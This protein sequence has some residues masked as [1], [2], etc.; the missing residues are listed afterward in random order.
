MID[1]K[2][3]PFFLDE[4]AIAWVHRTRDQMTVEEKAGQLFCVL[5]KEAKEEEFDYVYS[6]L[7]PGGCMYRVIPTDRAVAASNTLQRR[8][9]YCYIHET[10]IC[11]C[12]AV[13]YGTGLL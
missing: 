7:D 1:L 9:C 2:A 3:N 12:A 5:F 13:D 8:F 11:G 4:E 10:E 6:I